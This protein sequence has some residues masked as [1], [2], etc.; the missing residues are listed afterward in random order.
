M[1]CGKN[2]RLCADFTGKPTASLSSSFDA[3]S[4]MPF[5]IVVSDSSGVGLEISFGSAAAPTSK[6]ARHAASAAKRRSRF[7][8]LRGCAA[9][10]STFRKIRARISGVTSSFS[11]TSSYFVKV[12]RLL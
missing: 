2:G 10:A 9:C 6:M 11:I 1:L 4:T 8:F 7:G 5:A 3:T 12:V